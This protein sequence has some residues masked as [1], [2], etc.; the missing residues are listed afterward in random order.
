MRLQSYS[1]G[2]RGAICLLCYLLITSCNNSTNQ[3]AVGETYFPLQ[4]GLSWHYRVQTELTGGKRETVTLRIDNRGREVFRDQQYSVR[5]T[6]KGTD[7]YFRRQANGIY[8]YAKRTIVENKPALDAS[9]RLV[10][11]LPV[12]LKPG[13]SW[14]VLTQSYTLH[15]V[16]PN[17]E[18]PYENIAYF[19]MT[20]TLV[21][22]DT[23]VSVPAGQFKNCI[24]I[25]GQ[26]QIDQFSGA[27]EGDGEIEITTREWYAPG[28]GMVK[29]ERLEPLD[30]SVFKGGRVLIELVEFNES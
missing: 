7:Y 19:H 18:P 21:G 20:Y 29:M 16:I 13:K 26:A 30:G 14:S 25:E 22:L 5:R 4:K 6:S 3:N 24:L 8:R 11:P 9:P 2:M 10:L 1:T 12:P 23:E 15:R 27:N 28:V 17:Y